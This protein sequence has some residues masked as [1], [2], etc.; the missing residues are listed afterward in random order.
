[1]AGGARWR[2]RRSEAAWARYDAGQR[3]LLPPPG[4]GPVADSG[5]DNSPDAVQR[6]RRQVAEANIANQALNR[7]VSDLL[8]RNA[9]LLEDAKEARRNNGVIAAV[10]RLFS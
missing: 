1:M 2:W 7:Q 6:L 8:R 3:A 9:D 4:L 10:K 5:S